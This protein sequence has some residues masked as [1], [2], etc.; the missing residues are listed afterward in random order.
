MTFFC[1]IKT[2]DA[3]LYHLYCKTRTNMLQHS[4]YHSLFGVIM[5]LDTWVLKD[6][7]KVLFE[8]HHSHYFILN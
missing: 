7:K 5:G 4:D 6:P 2:V 3:Y 1:N 8:S